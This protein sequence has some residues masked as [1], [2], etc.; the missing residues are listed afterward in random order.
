MPDTDNWEPAPHE[1]QWFRNVNSG[2]RG[3]LVRTDGKDMIRLDRPTE[4]N[5]K[6]Y[7]PSDWVSDVQERPL[8][9][10]Q[11]A[12]VRFEAD[13]FLRYFTGNPQS[14]KDDWLNL[15]DE[16]RQL[17]IKRGPRKP[18]RADLWKAIGV[19]LEHLCR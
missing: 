16:Q 7:R 17:W 11:L 9:A 5:D 19:A 1:R 6:I 8:T 10:Y 2:E 4:T 15:T 13:K 12:R 3:Y 14:L 18:E